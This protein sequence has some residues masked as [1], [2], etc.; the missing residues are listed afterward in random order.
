MIP[1]LLAAVLTTSAATV[2][3]GY[4]AFFPSPG[5]GLPDLDL[6]TWFSA[7]RCRREGWRPIHKN[8]RALCR[9]PWKDY[10]GFSTPGT[11][12]DMDFAV[13]TTKAKATTP[14]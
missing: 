12:G 8:G 5:H 9:I 3:P 6:D 7:A 2:H 13:P 14:E 10:G 4:R 11:V 1:V